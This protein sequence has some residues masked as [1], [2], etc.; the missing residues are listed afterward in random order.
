MKRD[1]VFLFRHKK[2]EDN[3]QAFC[4]DTNSD[5]KHADIDA[6]AILSACHVSADRNV[7]YWN[8]HEYPKSCLQ[9]HTKR[10]KFFM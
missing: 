3:G 8:L 6:I 9:L 2:F 4:P 1:L 7:S 10:I 5:W